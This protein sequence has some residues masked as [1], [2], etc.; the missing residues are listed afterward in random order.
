MHVSVRIWSQ[1]GTA[2]GILRRK[3]LNEGHLENLDKGQ[4]RPPASIDRNLK[5]L[6]KPVGMITAASHPE[7]RDFQENT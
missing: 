4:G 7:A 5:E 6:R 2:P 3:G 1:T